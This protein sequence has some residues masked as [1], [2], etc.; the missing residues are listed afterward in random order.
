MNFTKIAAMS[1]AA[2]AGLLSGSAF[3]QTVKSVNGLMTDAQGMPLY[4]FAKDAPNRSSCSGV[5]MGEWPTFV[6][7]IGAMPGGGL[8]II[9]RDDGV[10]QWTY[11]DRPLYY[12]AVDVRPGD[13]AGGKQNE[14][15]AWLTVPFT[16]V[17]AVSDVS[18]AP[19]RYS[20]DIGY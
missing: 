18:T 13:L 8:G 11:K 12:H 3:A 1:V 10:Q 15:G 5:C 17:I 4:V 19:E 20:R 9:T 14:N 7:K 2:V 16:G 6:P